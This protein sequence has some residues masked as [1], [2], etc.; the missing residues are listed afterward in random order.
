MPDDFE[1]VETTSY[2]RM[3]GQLE[4]TVF[5]QEERPWRRFNGPA[6]PK[7]PMYEIHIADHRDRLSARGKDDEEERWP[8]THLTHISVYEIP[9]PDEALALAR[10]LQDI[11]AEHIP[12]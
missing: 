10:K 2:R 11:M 8:L 1:T 4:A 12:E 9:D 6:P 3:L 5:A 7:T